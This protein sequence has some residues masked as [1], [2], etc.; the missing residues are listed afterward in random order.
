MQ[1]IFVSYRPFVKDGGGG[2][3][4]CTNE[5]IDTLRRA[6]FKLEMCLFDSD[7]RLL[8]R[9]GRRLFSSPYFRPAEPG[10]CRQ[11]AQ[12]RERTRA[13]F[14]F[15]NQTTLASLAPHLK[16]MCPN[17]KIVVLS[18]G[19]ESTD[20]LHAV[21]LRDRLPITVKAWPAA[22][23]VVG[24]VMIKESKFR[25]SIDAVCALTSFDA[26]LE[27]WLGAQN[28]F[29]LPRTVSAAP[30]AWNPQPGRFGYVGTLDHAPNLEGL[31]NVLEVLSSVADE[32]IRVRIVGGPQKIGLWLSHKFPL[33]DYL[34]PLAHTELEAEA[35]SWNAFLHPIFLLARGC[36]TKLAT[37]LAWQ[38]PIVTTEFGHR[39]YLWRRG[40]FTTGRNPAD[41]ARRCLE[42]LDLECASA[43]RKE[44]VE[45]SSS[46]P[47]LD[48][49]A[50]KLKS[51]LEII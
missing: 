11:I 19:L 49:V 16:T 39:G 36:S 31:V 32:R 37:A 28:V 40:R 34:G 44:V 7:H 5:Y 46:S 45:I 8:T 3:Q 24:D 38:I 50:A 20:L 41:F 10:L 1:S 13:E 4:I 21:R 33:V 26:E 30:L 22:N 15:L 18:H 29:W 25:S 27:Q 48:E 14:I 35:A 51:N 43:A 9:I 47:S 42:L 12:V 17:S 23:F 2:V 6:G